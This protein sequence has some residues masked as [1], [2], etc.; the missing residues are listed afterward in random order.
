MP[1]V[2]VQFALDQEAQQADRL[3]MDERSAVPSTGLLQFLCQPR[4]SDSVVLFLR[5]MTA[6]HMLTHQNSFKL[7]NMQ[8]DDE[9]R[10]VVT[11]P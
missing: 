2:D 11:T 6:F 3:G 9:E 1:Y 10:L 4:Q 7:L 8:F 5:A